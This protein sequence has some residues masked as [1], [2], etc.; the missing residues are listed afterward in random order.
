[1]LSEVEVKVALKDECLLD[2]SVV[3]ILDGVREQIGYEP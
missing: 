3:N 1:M 2:I